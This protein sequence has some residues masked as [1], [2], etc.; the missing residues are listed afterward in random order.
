MSYTVV[1]AATARRDLEGISPRIVPAII[2][3]AFGELAQRP[4]EFGH[5]LQ[6]DLE[7]YCGARRGPYRIMFH[8]S[9]PSSQV[10]ILRVDHLVDSYRNS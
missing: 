9:G 2:E 3:F 4:E 7:G 10:E 5:L 8:M 6:R 1:F